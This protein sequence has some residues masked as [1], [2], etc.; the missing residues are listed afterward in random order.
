H[1]QLRAHLH[2]VHRRSLLDPGDHYRQLPRGSL[3]R[4]AKRAAVRPSLQAREMTRPPRIGLGHSAERLGIDRRRFLE[5]A[6]G[7]VGALVLAACDSQGPS[8]AQ[9]LLKFAERKNESVERVLLRHTS[10][11]VPRAGAHAAGSHFPSYYVSN[12]V[13]TW[14]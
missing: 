12:A 5:V 3:A 10:M 14:D 13:P 4:R 11:D 9:S 1:L 8:S 6:S 7:A 2:G